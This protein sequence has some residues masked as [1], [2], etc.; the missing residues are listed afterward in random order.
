SQADEAAA[1]A[2]L[3]QL[4]PRRPEQSHDAIRVC[5]ELID[6][7]L[8]NISAIGVKQRPRYTIDSQDS[9]P[10]AVGYEII[11]ILDS[12]RLRMYDG[13]DAVAAKAGYSADEALRERIRE[14]E[15]IIDLV[16][17]EN[18]LY[19]AQEVLNYFLVVRK[20]VTLLVNLSRQS[21]EAVTV[22]VGL[23]PK[24]EL[25]IFI[26]SENLAM[27]QV[28]DDA[29][30]AVIFL[31]SQPIGLD[32]QI[33]AGKKE[34]MCILSVYL[35]SCLYFDFDLSF[36]ELNSL[37]V[38]ISR[39]ERL[40]GIEDAFAVREIENLTPVFHELAIA[41]KR[42]GFIV[43]AVQ[44]LLS[45]IKNKNAKEFEQ[46]SSSTEKST[47]YRRPVLRQIRKIL[48]VDNDEMILGNF[49]RYLTDPAYTRHIYTVV[50][51]RDGKEALDI[52]N[53]PDNVAVPF[54][55]IL[56]EYSMPRMNGGVFAIQFRKR[57][58]LKTAQAKTPIIMITGFAH[59]EEFINH[60]VKTGILDAA[61]RKYD[62]SSYLLMMV[63]EIKQKEL[64][65]LNERELRGLLN[66]QQGFSFYSSSPIP[67][68][69]S[70]ETIFTIPADISDSGDIIFAERLRDLKDLYKEKGSRA[71]I[72][73]VMNDPDL[74]HEISSLLR[75]KFRDENTKGFDIS[76]KWAEDFYEASLQRAMD[77]VRE[78]DIIF[79]Q[80]E[81]NLSHEIFDLFRKHLAK[82]V[83]FIGKIKMTYRK[84]VTYR[85]IKLDIEGVAE[86]AAKIG[87]ACADYRN[88]TVY[89]ALS[90]NALKTGRTQGD[91]TNQ[92]KGLIR[93][94]SR[95]L[96]RKERE[97]KEL[98]GIIQRFAQKV[99]GDIKGGLLAR[100]TLYEKHVDLIKFL[101]GLIKAVENTASSGLLSKSNDI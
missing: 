98:T 55:L 74:E 88:R 94:M 75:C 92:A 87:E 53:H 63:E 100:K 54:D 30:G 34:A 25:F 86:T 22:L 70:G 67:S 71:V 5:V 39:F 1:L 9:G 79:L 41:F 28:A 93:Q 82:S 80:M 20:A 36:T 24:L 29:M 43:T 26:C 23:L 51:A 95:G 42:Y 76:D 19:F 101:D 68:G 10:L 91:I 7:F 84:V 45:K 85:G 77:A 37:E 40:V 81:Y 60:L 62:N 90:F 47:K 38:V 17:E 73:C 4:I 3:Y 32:G 50:A 99:S 65:P 11:N 15:R 96:E 97:A 2:S 18:L 49:T 56:V 57:E 8:E 13:T 72:N 83:R 61:V 33:P 16:T 21:A 66:K 14:F 31:A 46:A 35:K 59:D 69:V 27:Q 89:G 12:L 48:I 58:G 78:R 52:I 64:E 44:K 6:V